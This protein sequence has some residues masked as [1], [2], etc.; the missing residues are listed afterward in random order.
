M[1]IYDF[2][3][4]YNIDDSDIWCD[5]VI[6][7][8]CSGIKGWMPDH[9][10]KSICEL[11]ADCPAIHQLQKDCVVDF[12]NEDWSNQ[13]NWNVPKFIKLNSSWCLEWWTLECP[14]TDELVKTSAC[15]SH[16]WYLEEKIEWWTS[17]DWLYSIDVNTVSCDKLEITPEWPNNTYIRAWDVPATWSWDIRYKNGDIY[18]VE[19]LDTETT[20]NISYA[21]WYHWWWYALVP[22]SNW[23]TVWWVNNWESAWADQAFSWVSTLQWT[24]DIVRWTGVH[25][26]WLT[27]P[28]IYQI[29]LNSCLKNNNEN[30]LYAI[31]WWIVLDASGTTTQQY[32]WVVCWDVKYWWR[33]YT[34]DVNDFF[35]DWDS[36]QYNQAAR[37][38]DLWIMSFCSSYVLHLW[39]ASPDSP[40]WICYRVRY[41]TRV[42]FDPRNVNDPWVIW[43]EL[44]NDWPYE[45]W[46]LNPWTP[47][48]WT[49]TTITCAR[50]WE[51][52]RLR[53]L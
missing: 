20:S 37:H 43:L 5:K 33:R 4:G 38:L 48:E 23:W 28:W 15:D 50:I 25:I 32:A 16:S 3:N 21:R 13:Y 53:T 2:Y 51:Y 19:D 34:E 14:C 12:F 11:I 6:V 47:N 1:A 46:S 8:Q 40:V 39:N 42:Q 52:P 36:S 27:R 35:P 49:N 18:Y 29:C 7:S 22:T 31:R 44:T 17:S 45:P 10:Y 41:D 24:K 9:V 30:W 26:F